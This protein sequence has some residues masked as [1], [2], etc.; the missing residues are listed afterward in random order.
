[1]GF[2]RYIFALW[3][4]KATRFVMRLLRRRG[5]IFPGALA[6]KL[7][8]D[9]L[10]YV[11]KPKK[12]IAVTGT[13]GKTTVSNLLFDALTYDGL[14]VMGNRFGSNTAPGI[15]SCLL[16]GCGIF[17]RPKH[18]IAV[19]EID[20][21]SAKR[22]FSHIT[23]DLLIITNLFRD[24]IMRNAHPGFI[25]DFLTSAIP[26]R[27]R[28]ILNADDL[29]AS[30]VAPHN[31]HVYFGIGRMASD[32]TECQNLLNDIRVCPCC[33][34]DLVYEYRRYHHIGRAR[35]EKCAFASPE[36]DYAAKAVDLT[37][38]KMTVSDAAGSGEYRLLSDSVY[39]IYNE[40]TTISTLRELGYSHPRIA[41]LLEKCA[42][43][44]SRFNVKRVGNHDI[45]MQMAKEKNAL[46]CSRAFDYISSLPGEKEL[47]L[48]M[49]CLGDARDWSENTTWIYDCDFEFLRKDNIPLIVATGARARDYY[50][51]LLLAG[52]PE[53][54]LH[55]IEDEFEA[56][57]ALTFARDAYIFY[58]TDS[59]D[60]A[61]RVRD[62]AAAV[63]ERRHRDE[64]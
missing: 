30:S 26:T 54:S 15:I 45:I 34:A 14:R 29:I 60:L 31:K 28:L 24:S 5:T 4:A 32:V 2:I 9:F 41:E 64:V 17:G 12:I 58:G 6:L 1:M 7:C 36:Y 18:D 20:E 49:N 39:N 43:V 55:C 33:H 13:N 42:I 21:R 11:G 27:T 50:L 62:R 59:L 19:L 22:L 35:C 3:I 52:V 63:A 53:A 8:P 47:L 25:A 46:A 61:Y 40:L 57:E 44:S 16:T 51:R 10:Q 56:V 37:H 23:P 48:M 38:M